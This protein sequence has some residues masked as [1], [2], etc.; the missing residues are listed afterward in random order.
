MRRSHAQEA[1]N[2][3]I[4]VKGTNIQD[5]VKLF[6]TRKAAVDNMSASGMSDKAWRGIIIRSIPP[7]AKWLP[8]IPSL[9]AM[10]SSAD[11]TST[12]FAHGIILGRDD[13]GQ[14]STNPLNSALVARTT[15]GCKNPN[16]KAKKRSTHTTADCYWPGGGKEGQFPPGF[17]QRSKAATA[18]INSTT[19]NVEH[20]A[21]SVLIP[22][23]PD[24]QG[25]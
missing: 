5:H 11:I 20:F 14:K 13:P 25:S 12:L 23:T 22:N 4:Y 6:H 18:S 17:G 21:L 7:S 24:N 19:E 1:L 15:E 2:K 16:C 10:R 8:V 9:Y 3:T